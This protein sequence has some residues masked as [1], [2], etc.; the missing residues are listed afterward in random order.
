[1][2]QTSTPLTIEEAGNTV[3]IAVNIDK[4]V[5][6]PTLTVTSSLKVNRAGQ[7]DVDLAGSCSEEGRKVE[8]TI[9]SDPKVAVDC[10]ATGWV[11]ENLDLSDIADYPE[12]NIALILT[13]RD[14]IGN[15]ASISKAHTQIFKD[16]IP[17]QILRLFAT[18]ACYQYRKYNRLYL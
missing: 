5:T 15:E 16:T 13:H 7:S 1:M 10:T 3:S 6:A 4:D 11:Y 2:E 9:G 18:L 17:P 8:I 14:E 12:G